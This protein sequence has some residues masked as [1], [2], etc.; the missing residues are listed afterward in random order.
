M[1]QL[2]AEMSSA[3]WAYNFTVHLVTVFRYCVNTYTNLGTA[4]AL[5]AVSIFILWAIVYYSTGFALYQAYSFCDGYMPQKLTAAIT[6][7]H[8]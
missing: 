5:M 4:D 2:I 1:E 8:F 3:V 7:S 6:P